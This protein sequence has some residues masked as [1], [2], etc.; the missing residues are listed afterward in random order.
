[1]N[2]IV[3]PFSLYRTQLDFEWERPKFN[4]ESCYIIQSSIYP[5]FLAAASSS[6]AAGSQWLEQ[7]ELATEYQQPLVE[8]FAPLTV[9][10]VRPNLKHQHVSLRECGV[11]SCLHDSI[12]K[13]PTTISHIRTPIQRAHQNATGYY[14]SR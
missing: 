2:T 9:R 6:T 13:S 1:M 5:N 14:S 3:T 8:N 7:R 10:H 11:D 4:K 12:R